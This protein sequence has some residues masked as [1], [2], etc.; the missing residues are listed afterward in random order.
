MQSDPVDGPLETLL[1]GG[2]S[3][4]EFS[5]RARASDPDLKVIFM[6]GYSAGAAKDGGF[7]DSEKLLLRKPF[8]RRQL[9][10]ALREALD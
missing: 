5:A 9:A 2:M 7:L 8:Q 6:S 1:R 3:G 4:P 10:K